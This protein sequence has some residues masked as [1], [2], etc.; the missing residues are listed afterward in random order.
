MGIDR[1]VVAVVNAT[2]DHIR[3]TRAD[4]GECQLHAIN[5]CTV[6]RPYL[7]TLPLLTYLEAQGDGCREGT[8]VAAAGIIRSANNDV[9]HI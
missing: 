7:N 1:S 5:G 6:A 3:L 9:T 8:G 2:N 4:L